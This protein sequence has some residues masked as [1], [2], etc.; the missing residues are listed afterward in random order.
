MST[1]TP[2]ANQTVEII[3]VIPCGGPPDYL[4]KTWFYKGTTAHFNVTV[5]NNGSASRRVLGAINVY[6]VNLTPLGISSFEGTVIGG[7]TASWIFTFP[8]PDT[9]STGNAQVYASALAGWPRDNGTAY[10]PE[11]PATFEIRESGSAGA[12]TSLPQNPS[13][14]PEGTYNLTFRLGSDARLG[15]YTVYAA[16]DYITDG[17]YQKAV[18][19]VI[20]KL[21]GPWDINGDGK[22]NIID[23]VI[24]A[25]AFDSRPG[26]PNWNPKADIAPEFGVVNIVDIVAVAIHWTG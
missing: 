19:N 23:I 10:C 8:I 26:D 13:S 2:P 4:P 21:G 6:D 24:V 15:N 14:S 1:G 22:V 18:T 9:A 17:Y 20:F 16:S 25:L 3:S 12:S 7:S 11:K 5:K